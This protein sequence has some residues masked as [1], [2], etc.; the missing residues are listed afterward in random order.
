VARKIRKGPLDAVDLSGGRCQQP[1]IP[2]TDERV[3]WRRRWKRR[4]AASP[5]LLLPGR[6]PDLKLKD[7]DPRAVAYDLADG[8]TVAR[9]VSDA[10]KM[11]SDYDRQR[12]AHPLCRVCPRSRTFD[13]SA[14]SARESS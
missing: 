13:S 14:P 10:D 6:H 5:P 4:A 12:R 3:V 11:A 1:P 9:K 8:S 7:S 2:K